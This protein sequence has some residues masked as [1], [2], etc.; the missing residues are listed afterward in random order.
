L[1]P[2][3]FLIQRFKD[4]KIQKFFAVTAKNTSSRRNPSPEDTAGLLHCVRKDGVK[5][6]FSG[7]L[8]P[9][10]KLCPA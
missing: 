9:Y 8:L 5:H 4:S 1:Y 10:G 2:R 3:F 6:F 7:S